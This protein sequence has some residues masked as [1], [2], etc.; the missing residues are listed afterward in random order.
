MTILTT[1]NEE[2]QE[3]YEESFGWSENYALDD[4]QKEFITN[5]NKQ[6]YIK[7]AEGEIK[8]LESLKRKL[9]GAEPLHITE[10]TE[11]HNCVL[12]YSIQHWQEIVDNFKKDDN[13]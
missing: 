4:K 9:T 11:G 12:K 13:A 6:L 1:H 10:W 8:R 5:Q 2:M 7:I 3:K